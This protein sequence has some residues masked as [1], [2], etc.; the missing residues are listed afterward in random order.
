MAGLV[1]I[2]TIETVLGI[3]LGIQSDAFDV[4]GRP[5]RDGGELLGGFE[6]TLK[7]PCEV[8]ASLV[9]ASP[10]SAAEHS[11]DLPPTRCNGDLEPDFSMGLSEK[12][13][14]LHT[15]GTGGLGAYGKS[16][17]RKPTGHAIFDGSVSIFGVV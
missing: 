9:G 13:G 14:P 10:E 1:L 16:G 3:E 5:G 4:D 15:L 7:P 2:V 17:S 8:N 12:S 11:L 6:G